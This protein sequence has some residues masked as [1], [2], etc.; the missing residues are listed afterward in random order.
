MLTRAILTGGVLSA[1]VGCIVYFGTTGLDARAGDNQKD[2]RVEEIKLAGGPDVAAGTEEGS[3]TKSVI[4]T[5]TKSEAVAK[6]EA[7]VEDLEVKADPELAD[8]TQMKKSEP[9]TKWLDQYLK[10]T[11]PNADSKPEKKLSSKK[12]EMKHK[13]DAMKEKADAMAAKLETAEVDGEPQIEIMKDKVEAMRKSHAERKMRKR[14]KFKKRMKDADTDMAETDHD[15]MMKDEGETRDI[16]I[17]IDAIDVEALELDGEIDVDVLK[18]QL[19]LEGEKNVEIR[20]IKKMNRKGSHGVKMMSQ[21][22]GFD[23]DAVLE[24]ARKLLIPDMR[25]QAVLEIVDFAVD[26][27]DM[28]EAAD[29][30]QEIS[31][32]ELRDT[33]RARI[34]AG[35]ARCGKPEAAFAIID[36]L[37]LDELAAPIRLE[38][39]TVLMATQQERQAAGIRNKRRHHAH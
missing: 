18:K 22:S 34:G 36:E 15:A 21:S 11:K 9:K 16:E 31:T 39:I 14:F 10:K 20:V 37:E 7:V 33:A 8:A 13:A 6:S 24:E 28:A 26:N 4:K 5:V 3:S 17:D 35:L 32:P 23:Y 25:D 29:L 27:L 38:I 1:V 12:V 19:G 2:V 30:V